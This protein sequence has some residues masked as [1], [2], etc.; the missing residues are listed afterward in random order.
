MKL[1]AMAITSQQ[2]EKIETTLRE[3][4]LDPEALH[5]WVMRRVYAADA[6]GR[7][8]THYTRVRGSHGEAY[9]WNREGTDELPIGYEAPRPPLEVA[10]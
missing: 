7:R 6:E 9:V 3:L 2:A 1:F 10:R 4:G 5:D 8:L